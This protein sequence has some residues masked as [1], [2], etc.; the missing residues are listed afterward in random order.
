MKNFS[1]IQMLAIVVTACLTLTAAASAQTYRETTFTYGSDGLPQTVTAVDPSGPDLTTRFEWDSQGNLTH[2]I[3]PMGRVAQGEYRNDRRLTRIIGAAQ[4]ST[5][6]SLSEFFYDAGGRLYFSRTALSVSGTAWTGSLGAGTSSPASLTGSNWLTTEVVYNEW[7]KVDRIID[8]DG[9]ESEFRYLANDLLL[10][11][12][13]G[14]GRVSRLSYYED[15]SVYC[16]QVAAQTAD[17][18]TLRMN[19]TTASGNPFRWWNG[20]T[21]HDCQPGATQ[22]DDDTDAFGSGYTAFDVFFRPTAFIYETD[23]VDWDVDA[24]G[25]RLWFYTRANQYFNYAYDDSNRL[26]TETV[27]EGTNTYTY[28][29]AGE[30]ETA[31]W[32][33]AGYTAGISYTYDAFGRVTEENRTQD[34]WDVDYEYDASGAR[35][36]IIWPD[37]WAARYL[38]DDAGRL[39]FV[40]EDADNNGA[41]EVTLAQYAY[42][43]VGRRTQV[44]FHGAIGAGTSGVT[45]AYE[46][47]G[48]LVQLAHQFDN[49]IDVAFSHSYDAS[50]RL[51]ATHTSQNGWL[52]SANGDDFTRAYDVDFSERVTNPLLDDWDQISGHVDTGDLTGSDYYLYDDN[53]NLSNRGSSLYIH[54]SR[55]RLTTIGTWLTGGGWQPASTGV[56]NSLSMRYD[57]SGRRINLTS[58]A[59]TNLIFVHAGD[60]EIA[61]VNDQSGAT[62]YGQIIRRYVPGAD[63]DERVV[64]ITTSAGMGYGGNPAT[65]ASYEYYHSDRQGNVI[66]MID[67]AGTQTEQYVYTPFGVE[68]L[69]NTTGNPFRY[70]GRRLDRDSGLYYYRA[71]YFDPALGRFIQTDPV[72][73]DDQMNMYAYVGNNPLNVGDPS[74]MRR[75]DSL[76][77][78]GVR[79]GIAG[80][81]ANGLQ[82][83]GDLIYTMSDGSQTTSSSAASPAPLSIDQSPSSD[84]AKSNPASG[85]SN[86]PPTSPLLVEFGVLGVDSD[87]SNWDYIQRRHTLFGSE[88]SSRKSTFLFSLTFDRAA[89]ENSLVRPALSLFVVDVRQRHVTDLTLEPY[90]QVYSYFPFIVGSTGGMGS[91]GT[92]WVRTTLAST[93][94]PGIYIIKNMFPDSPP[95]GFTS[96]KS[97]VIKQVLAIAKIQKGLRSMGTSARRPSIVFSFPANWRQRSRIVGIE[98]DVALHYDEVVVV[99]DSILVADFLSELLDGFILRNKSTVS[100]QGGILFRLEFS[101]D[102]MIAVEVLDGDSFSLSPNDARSFVVEAFDSILMMDIDAEYRQHLTEVR[103][104]LASGSYD[105]LH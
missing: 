12:E 2:V 20:N 102:Q 52:W 76:F 43:R 48:D 53:G 17:P 16:T 40:C 60:M 30:R 97:M 80:R 45:Y 44:E 98:A 71:R 6:A 19:Y 47:D 68:A 72:G 14:E 94:R 34:A 59:S 61:E 57:P 51:T 27:P 66:A 1:P 29:H 83:N 15:G 103:N 87:A 38:Y 42:D 74:G 62:A 69:Y 105:G 56:W 85:E 101:D 22:Y 41:C 77:G 90:I 81:A 54:D 96:Y 84:T 55:S 37:G 86:V 63:V 11:S 91:E 9:D 99:Y 13:D 32:T 31:S 49:A 100:D 26:L 4:S 8:A 88:N 70:N 7:G 58:T 46:N 33:G 93:S 79:G 24:A 67:A 18:R 10:E 36:A 50:G 89:W 35:T 25:N 5:D 23:F 73:Y 3:D 64:M 65:S 92:H 95:S 28:N 82:G 104:E 39:E 78:K 21:A 75:S